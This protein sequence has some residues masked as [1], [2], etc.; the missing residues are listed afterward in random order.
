[1]QQDVQRALT[2]IPRTSVGQAVAEYNPFALA[3]N[4]VN[5][6]AGWAEKIAAPPATSGPLQSA[7]GYGVHEAVNQLPMLAGLKAPVAAS[8]AA[9][10]MNAL[11][12]ETMQSALKPPLKALE[13]G[14]AGQAIDTM[15]DQGI[16]V[17][18]GGAEKL[19]ARIEVINDAI[20]D[21]INNSPAIIDKAAVANRLNG[22]VAKFQKQVTPLSDVAAIQKAYDEFINHPLLS[23]DTI[24]VQTAQAIKQGT[25]KAL[26]NK[27]YGE[28]KGADIEAQKGLARG[29]KDEIASA[30]PAVRPLNAEESQLL[31]ALSLVERR[32]LISANKN[33]MGLGL[34]TTN[35][36]H[37]LGF[38]ADRSELFKSL[39]ARMLSSTAK[40]IP[41][42]DIAGPVIGAAT[43]QQANQQQG[44]QR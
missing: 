34:L 21:Y 13:T 36:V 38:M 10:G 18:R 2:Y 40:A 39:V 17:T 27:S 12:R 43:T 42:A 5:A 1:M 26:G 25:Y 22:L 4:A 30:V 6:L 15:L 31:N 11:A 9:E 16:N 37:F 19:N 14:K 8:A 41:E 24:P 3:G 28:L 35:P 29:L 20:K 44:V 7:L 23:G 32:V 33:P